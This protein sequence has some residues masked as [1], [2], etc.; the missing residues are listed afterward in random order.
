MGL[1]DFENFSFRMILTNYYLISS[2]SASF[3][4]VRDICVKGLV[5]RD[6]PGYVDTSK[7]Y[8]LFRMFLHLNRN[9]TKGSLLCKEPIH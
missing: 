2:F 5:E 4:S 7:I 8:L 3:F 1:H 9:V 6:L